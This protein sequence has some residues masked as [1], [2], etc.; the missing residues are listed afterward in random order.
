MK[1]RSI[2]LTPPGYPFPTR[3][4]T[5]SQFSALQESSDN[6]AERTVLGLSLETRA[7]RCSTAVMFEMH[8][9]RPI[10][11]WVLY[12][13]TLEM[14]ASNHTATKPSCTDVAAKIFEFSEQR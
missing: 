7:V 11:S 9:Q 14:E 3:T 1:P 5:Q 6:G 4:L 12:G 8:E 13:Q 10:V 2:V